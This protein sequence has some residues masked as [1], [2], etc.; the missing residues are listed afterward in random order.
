MWEPCRPFS[1]KL[2]SLVFIHINTCMHAYIHVFT[3]KCCLYIDFL[4][5]VGHR[6]FTSLNCIDTFTSILSLSSFFH[7]SH[8]R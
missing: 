6:L 7:S 3:D 2:F 5:T 4:N 8:E 1:L